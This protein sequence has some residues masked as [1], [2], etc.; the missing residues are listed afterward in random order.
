MRIKLIPFCGV[1][2][3][4]YFLI[5][6]QI[7]QEI[8]IQQITV[9]DKAPKGGKGGRGKNDANNKLRENILLDISEEKIPEV[10]YEDETY[11]EKWIHIRDE[12]IP[13]LKGLCPEK[14]DSY[15][16]T[17]KG[18]RKFNYDFSVD[19]YD[20]EKIVYSIEK[21]EF[22][23]GAKSI[24]LHPQIYQKNTNWDIQDKQYHDYF[25]DHGLPHILA[26]DPQSPPIIERE[27]YNKLVM[28]TNPKCHPFFEYLR[29]AE[30][31]ESVKRK[32]IV[33]KT[34]AD[35]LKEYGPAINLEKFGKTMM[36]TQSGKQYVLYDP[37][38]K[39]FY[40]DRA[41]FSVDSLVFGGVVKNNTIVVN[42]GKYKF[43]LLLRWK[44]RQG[45]LHTAWQVSLKLLS[46]K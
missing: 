8:T 14:F 13:K 10:F 23:F 21:L 36:E 22:K 7:M 31:L 15:K 25:Y 4:S 35:Y 33:K 26:L 29:R 37:T 32:A 16:M 2:L 20:S 30:E 39:K 28:N 43:G 34:I 11:G 24:H 12:F 19:Y 40:L 41:D 38:S 3:K 27:L 17:K 45:V 1:S 18:E 6:I 44:N 42:S 5:Y 46:S 9:F